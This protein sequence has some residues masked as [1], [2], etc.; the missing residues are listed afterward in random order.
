MLACLSAN[1]ECSASY[2]DIAILEDVT[3]DNIDE[4]KTVDYFKWLVKSLPDP[5]PQF[6]RSW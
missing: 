2:K 3:K 4:G 6:G 1:Q 5:K